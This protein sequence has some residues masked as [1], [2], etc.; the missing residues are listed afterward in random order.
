LSATQ[1]VAAEFSGRAGEFRCFGREKRFNG[2][3]RFI[4]LKK[5]S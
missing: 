4:C 1:A 3:V 2:S 5:S